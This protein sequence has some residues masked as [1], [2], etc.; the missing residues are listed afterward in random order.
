MN[1]GSRKH[2]KALEMAPKA[3]QI[4][5]GVPPTDVLGECRRRG[6]TTVG[7]A[8][9]PDEA[10]ALDEAGVDLIVASGFEAGGHRGS[11]LESA[12]ASLTGTMALVPV[13]A[14]EVR[15]PVIAAGGIADGRGV[16]AALALGAQGV[17][18]G[19]AFLACEESAASPAHRALL[20]GPESR[21]TA[22]TRAFTGR[23]ARAIPN[24]LSRDL[25]EDGGAA[26][27][28]PYPFQVWFLKHL[29]PALVREGRTDLMYVWS[30]Q[31]APALAAHPRRRPLPRASGGDRPRHRADGDGHTAR[32]GP[33]PTAVAAPT[34]ASGL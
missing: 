29:R 20:H 26:A 18:I 21:R 6:I 1:S 32:R 22:L 16:V 31:A 19:T 27:I 17:Q 2:P 14:D 8:T 24:R 28:A 11:F 30:G 12:Q 33:T 4:I 34:A 25:E 5:A 13:V 15:A 23:F 3:C 7:T 9:T 10:V